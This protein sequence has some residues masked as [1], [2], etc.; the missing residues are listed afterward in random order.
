MKQ[1]NKITQEDSGIT[2]NTLKD[3]I[4]KRCPN[5]QSPCSIIF[6]IGENLQSFNAVVDIF[7]KKG[8]VVQEF[9][10]DF[11]CVL[12]RE[13]DVINESVKIEGNQVQIQAWK[14]TL[15]DLCDD[16]ADYC[17]EFVGN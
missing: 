10:D 17:K 1:I 14:D 11:M 15:L 4:S 13:K 5:P 16:L 3:E 9:V 12:S 6:K 8:F 2:N 7:T